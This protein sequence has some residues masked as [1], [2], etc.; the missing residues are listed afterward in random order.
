MPSVAVMTSLTVGP[1]RYQIY[2]ETELLC[3]KL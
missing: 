2:V 3:Y 1:E